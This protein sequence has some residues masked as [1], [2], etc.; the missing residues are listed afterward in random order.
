MDEHKSEQRVGAAAVVLDRPGRWES[1]GSRLERAEY[2]AQGLWHPLGPVWNSFT[3]VGF[4]W[5]LSPK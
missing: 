5:I 4:A 2:S 3:I 1:E